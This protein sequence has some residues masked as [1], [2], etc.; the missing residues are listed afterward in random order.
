MAPR[1]KP[2]IVVVSALLICGIYAGWT[3]LGRDCGPNAGTNFR[4]DFS[5]MTS[6]VEHCGAGRFNCDARLPHWQQPIVV[7]IYSEEIEDSQIDLVQTITFRALGEIREVSSIKIVHETQMEPN[8]F[9]YIM[10]DL[11]AERLSLPDAS[12]LDF[13][14]GSLHRRAYDD[15]SCSARLWSTRLSELGPDEYQ[16]S[17]ASAIFVHHSLEGAELES[18]IYEE[19]AGVVGLSNDPEGQPSL[20]STGNYDIVDGQFRYSQRLLLMFR[21]IYRIAA[22]EYDDINAFCDAQD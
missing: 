3:Y 18:C 5:Y 2:I 6:T 21:A 17:E 19:V 11:M 14:V 4:E 1:N 9:V 7:S 15:R 20:F 13:R 22:G 10:N 8:F 12:S 16:T